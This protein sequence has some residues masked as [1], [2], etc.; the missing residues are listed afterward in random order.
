MYVNTYIS[1]PYYIKMI[2][3]KDLGHHHSHGDHGHASS[4]GGYGS[5]G[6]PVEP[7]PPPRRNLN[8]DAAYLHVIGNCM[9]FF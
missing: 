6:A 1:Y 9:L 4:P 8:I 3:N 7:P 2:E 5:I